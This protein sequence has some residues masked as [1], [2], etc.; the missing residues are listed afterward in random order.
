MRLYLRVVNTQEFVGGRHHVDLVRF[1]F[2]SLF[3]HELVNRLV[4]G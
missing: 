4:W 3:V 1:A 2:S